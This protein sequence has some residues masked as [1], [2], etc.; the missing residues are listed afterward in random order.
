MNCSLSLCGHCQFVTWLIGHTS[1]SYGRSQEVETTLRQLKYVNWL[2]QKQSTCMYHQNQ[3]MH[4]SSI[5]IRHTKSWRYD[6]V[7]VSLAIYSHKSVAYTKHS[8]SVLIQMYSYH[9]Q[10]FKLHTLL[11]VTELRRWWL[12]FMLSTS[13][14]IVDNSVVIPISHNICLRTCISL[15]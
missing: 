5:H 9:T 2:V 7:G 14:L 1:K 15:W 3:M 10:T 11:G 12:D 13:F 6:S 4:S 8:V